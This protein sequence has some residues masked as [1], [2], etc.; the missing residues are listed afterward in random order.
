MSHTDVWEC[1]DT[2]AC[3]CPYTRLAVVGV[4]NTGLAGVGVSNTGVG[5]S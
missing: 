3:V 4:S 1:P 2:G 5:V